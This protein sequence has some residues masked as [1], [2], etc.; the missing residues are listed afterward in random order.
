MYTSLLLMIIFRFSAVWRS[1]SRPNF[2]QSCHFEAAP[3]ESMGIVLNYYYYLIILS[4][5]LN[6]FYILVR[7]YFK[8]LKH[9]PPPL[10]LASL[11][12][13]VLW[14]TP[15]PTPP[16]LLKICHI[17]HNN[18]FCPNYSFNLSLVVLLFYCPSYFCTS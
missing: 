3:A 12:C 1:R 17:H 11:M 9:P 8:A 4:D 14:I 16:F 18:W 13:A 6:L 10:T 15:H 7:P 5:A 2:C